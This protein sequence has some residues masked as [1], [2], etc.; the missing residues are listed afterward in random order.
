MFALSL[1]PSFLVLTFS[2]M[3][4]DYFV[5]GCK[6]ESGFSVILVPR[7]DTVETKLIKTSYSTTAGTAFVEF[8]NT[9]V[10][11]EGLLGKEHQGFIVIS[12][13]FPS[14]QSMHQT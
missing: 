10:P 4:C 7:D 9:K 3:F 11:V 14:P 1:N 6:T 2:G 12:K 13:C 5:V 8:N